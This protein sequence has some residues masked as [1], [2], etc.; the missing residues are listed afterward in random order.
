MKTEPDKIPDL[1]SD[2]DDD[3]LV[4][5]TTLIS[6]TANL[7]SAK[8][9]VYVLMIG[10]TQFLWGL[11]GNLL[12]FS[13]SP[14]FRPFYTATMGTDPFAL[15]TSVLNLIGFSSSSIIWNLVFYSVGAVIFAVVC[16][17]AIR[18]ILNIYR[19]HLQGN[20]KTCFSFA[21]SRAGTLISIQLVIGSVV[22]LIVSPILI[23][24]VEGIVVLYPIQPY[25]YLNALIYYLPP[26]VICFL[27][28]FYVSVRFTLAPVAAL[29]E[30]LN[31]QNSLRRS[32]ELTRGNLIHT[33]KGALLIMILLGVLTS[34]MTFLAL[35]LFFGFSVWM[36]IIPAAINQLFLSPIFCVFEVVL[37]MDLLARKKSKNSNWWNQ[38]IGNGK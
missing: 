30:D 4:N 25:S 28:A 34:A 6:K 3:F 10:L 35:M 2:V 12:F 9:G 20:A 36:T 33:F 8:I 5:V 1:A 16:G 24:L 37:Y 32:W 21:K 15:L 23:A 14:F 19:D 13:S 31:M 7:Y 22:L 11:L 18:Y 26:V 38:S 29:A 27:G 17:G